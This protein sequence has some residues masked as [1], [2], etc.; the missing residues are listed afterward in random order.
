MTFF[1]GN[2]VGVMV[3]GFIADKFGRKF[4][5]LLFLTL[6]IVF[7][8]GSSHVSNFFLWL[9]CRFMCGA[10]SIGY[11][12]ALV[13]WMVEHTHGKWRSLL[14]HM[15]AD[16]A[17]HLGILLLAAL[18]YFN[19][20][21]VKLE[22]IIGLAN[23]PFLLLWFIM[24]KSPRW[25]LAKERKPEAKIA[26]NRICQWNKLPAVNVDE[27]VNSYTKEKIMTGRYF[28][29]FEHPSIR[30][31]TI[32]MCFVWFSFSMGFYGLT[33]NTPSLDWN[34]F[35]VFA[36]PAIFN[37]S[38]QY[39]VPFIENRFG[40]KF[41]VTFP[42]VSAG[43]LLVVT[44]LLPRGSQV[45]IVLAWIGTICCGIAF[46]S[47]YIYTKELY[48]TSVRTQAVSTASASA[49]LGS[50]ISPFIALLEDIHYLLPIVTYGAILFTA[51]FLSIWIWPETKKTRL[52]DT[53]EDTKI[54]ASGENTWTS[55][56][57]CK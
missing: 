25:L 44:T 42:V 4:G 21:M 1:A 48:P 36:F 52:P 2:F 49:R 46:G 50:I 22:L 27:F 51:G 7:G 47:G 24:P 40:R 8:A 11:Y 33:Y 41:M 39:F 12:N 32:L 35:L 53:M 3:S 31:N 37:F 16:A 18:V 45:I 29:L 55:W 57:K 5:Y 9:L 38:L 20:D 14:A 6:W 54:L 56:S 17:Y 43:I 13:V 19:R 10:L 34:V 28:D 30:R 26:M 15:F 23:L